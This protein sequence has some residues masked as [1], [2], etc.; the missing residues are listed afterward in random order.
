MTHISSHLQ[1][2]QDLLSLLRKNHTLDVR[3]SPHLQDG[4]PVKN[5]ST[6][7]AASPAESNASDLD[8]CLCTYVDCDEV[9]SYSREDK[10]EGRPILCTAHK[11]P[12]TVTSTLSQQCENRTCTTKP[13][14]SAHGATNGRWCSKH[15]PPGTVRVLKRL[16]HAHDCDRV[17]H[18]NLLGSLRGLYCSTHKLSHMVDVVRKKCREA[19]CTKCPHY[20]LPGSTLG[21]YCCAHKEQGMV[22]VHQQRCVHLDCATKP[23]FNVEG[24]SGAKY[25]SVH[26]QPGMVNLLYE[27]DKIVAAARK[28]RRSAEKEALTGGSQLAGHQ[29]GSFR[30][31][32]A[33][34]LGDHATNRRRE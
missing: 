3:L 10:S 24:A 19:G 31:Y 1:P 7:P 8:V 5:L 26:Q 32:Q 12:S 11:Q 17:P 9:A 30:R 25:C 18:F 2:S 28:R 16:C 23:S 33:S 22:H 13:T 6:Q 15:K 27:R 4:N 21:V 34:S 14:F 20:N 29:E